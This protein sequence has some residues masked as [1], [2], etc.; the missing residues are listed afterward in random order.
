MLVFESS[1]AFA[2]LP[3]EVTVHRRYPS[4]SK[5][6]ALDFHPTL[7]VFSILPPE[8]AGVLNILLQTK[9]CPLPPRDVSLADK[10]PSTGLAIPTWLKLPAVQ[11]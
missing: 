4:L 6:G 3:H 9:D 2:T 1:F 11:F 7:A 5:L 10:R 8:P